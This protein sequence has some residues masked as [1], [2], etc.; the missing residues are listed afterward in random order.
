MYFGLNWTL[1][2][3]I[4]RHDGGSSLREVLQIVETEGVPPGSEAGTRKLVKAG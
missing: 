4:G 1:G 3:A 2:D